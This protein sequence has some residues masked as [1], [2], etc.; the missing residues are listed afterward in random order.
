M[1]LEAWKFLTKSWDAAERDRQQQERAALVF[2]ESIERNDWSACSKLIERGCS[3]NMALG[4][5][6]ALMAAAEHGALETL[7]LL[8]STGAN[9]GAQDET[10]RDALFWA[11]ESR[12]DDLLDFL[13]AQGVR[14]KRLFGD[15]STALIHAAKN[16]YVHGVRSLVL[17][18][19]NLVNQYDRMGRTALWHV[20]SKTDLS[21]EDNEI[22][23]IL[24]DEGADP[25]LLDIEGISARQSAQA[26]SA[27]SLIE[28]HDLSQAMD[29]ESEADLSADQ[30]PA[31]RSNRP[32]L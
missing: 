19:K 17:Y 1:R 2:F 23:R 25:D 3:A 11:L 12:R 20:L 14:P 6:T 28:R 29:A 16:S 18:D 7:R 10:G 15:N 31:P 21:D 5:K 13:L 22:A 8:V 24:M 32:R 30:T 9:L 4:Q 27:Q 26:E